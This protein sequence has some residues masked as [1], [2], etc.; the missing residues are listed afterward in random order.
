MMILL[1][2]QGASVCH[3]KE[4]TEKVSPIR[5]KAGAG[6]S[7]LA[8]LSPGAEFTTTLS[9]GCGIAPCRFQSGLWGLVLQS[10]TG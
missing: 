1:R 4:A 3:G 8:L 6:F 9:K 5:G 7:I 10:N 2:S